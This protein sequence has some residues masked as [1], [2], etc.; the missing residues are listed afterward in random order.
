[1]P[2]DRELQLALELLLFLDDGVEL[3]GRFLC[4]VLRVDRLFL[5]HAQIVAHR[6]AGLVERNLQLVILFLSVF[7]SVGEGFTILHRGVAF[8]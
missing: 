8:S 4:D 3:G 6:E 7:E 2:I 5:L 1:M